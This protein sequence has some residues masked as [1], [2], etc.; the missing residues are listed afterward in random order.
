MKS[1]KHL[2]L[3]DR[4]TIQ[5][6]V[7]QSLSFKTI[8]AQL[9]K[10]ASTIAK[11]V[12]RHLIVKNTSSATRRYNPCAKADA[13][14]Q[15]HLCTQRCSKYCKNCGK[16]FQY[17]REFVYME[18]PKLK[19][20]PYCCNPCKSKLHCSLTKHYYYAQLAQKA[21]ETKIRDNRTGYCIT[22]EEAEKISKYLEPLVLQGQSIHHICAT[23]KDEIMFCEKTIYTY[24]DAGVFQLKNIDLP[25]KVRYKLRKKPKEYK[26]DKK[27]RQ[28]R[29]YAD[30][31]AF[32]REN[33]EPAL[34]QMDTV[35]G[36]KTGK[37]LLTLLFVSCGFML[38]YLREDNSAKSVK[39]IFQTLH[40]QLGDELFR[41][42]FPVILTD[43]GSEFSDPV[44]LEF[45]SNTGERMTYI[46]YCDVRHS[47][48]KGSIEVNHEFIRRIS[49]KGVSLDKLTQANIDLM[50][51]HINS[52]K[53]KK[54]N[55]LSPIE[56]FER[57]YGKG[58]A[59]RLNIF[60]INSDDIILTPKLLKKN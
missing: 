57:Y 23:H 27:C 24:I 54:Y 33:D 6:G 47:E 7:T 30:F 25:R 19:V 60:R 51:S 52:Y 12:K 34:V 13:C 36:S 9:G 1:Y 2:T 3:Q 5:C 46:F 31:L 10:D 20:P 28:D 43:N 59:E 29:T 26:V 8:A 35:K 48:Q 38:A 17:C 15:K 11:E 42:L 39:D 14:T 45:D 58:V 56:L 37:T 18:Y 44:S 55:D 21:Y 16:C 40:K 53:R 22:L 49:P 41:T 4:I 50:M 32:M